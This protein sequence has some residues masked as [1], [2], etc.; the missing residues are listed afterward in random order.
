MEGLLAGSEA[1]SGLKSPPWPG[2]LLGAI[3]PAKAQKG[4]EPY[5]LRCQHCHLPP[6]RSPEIQEEKYW[7]AGLQ[8]NRN[9]NPGK[10]VIGP[11]LRDEERWAMI[12][13]LKTL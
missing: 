2:E 9:N 3:D 1:F 4:S 6:I 5:K 13:Y 8:G 7:E 11:E 10:G 12:E